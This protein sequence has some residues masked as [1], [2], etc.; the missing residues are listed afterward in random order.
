MIRKIRFG[1]FET[2]SSSM[3]SLVVLKDSKVPK[4]QED[5]FY[6]RKDGT[7][8]I[9]DEED[10][11]FGRYPFEILSKP[12]DKFRYLLASFSHDKKM[13]N[14]IIEDFK[15]LNPDVKDIEFPNAHFGSGKFYGD[16]DHESVGLVTDYIKDNNLTFEEFMKNPKYKIIID[17]DEY[18]AWDDMKES[19]LIDLDAIEYEINPYEKWRQEHNEEDDLDEEEDKIEER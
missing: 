15:K 17:G 2:N 18:G 3:H 16:I 6:V 11:E 14:K 12:S 13:R 4:S 8:E 9:W 10:L 5:Y 19:G 7:Y 1:T